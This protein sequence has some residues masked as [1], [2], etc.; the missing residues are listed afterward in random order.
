MQADRFFDTT[1]GRI[2]AELRGKRGVSAYDISVSFGLSPNAIR[3]QL[4]ILERDGLVVGRAVRRGKTK[5][6]IEFA[7]TPAGEQLFP[8]RYDKMLN[9]VLREVR[10]IGG[11]AMVTQVFEGMGQRSAA[12]FNAKMTGA[13]GTQE[14]AEALVVQLREQGVDAEIVRVGDGFA[15]REHTCPYANTVGEH[16]EV[17]SVIHTIL[18]EVV[19]G[20][21]RHVESLATGGHECRF[22]LQEETRGPRLVHPL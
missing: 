4:T 12:K 11:D 19:P 17:C 10:K 13:V 18:K 16:P 14:R 22:E 7:L 3:Q 2:V 1:R 8:Q 21:V 5:P 15:I 6:T 20:D 9:S